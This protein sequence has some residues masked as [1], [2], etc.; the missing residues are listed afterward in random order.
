MGYLD[1]S[2]D[3]PHVMD[4][5]QTERSDSAT[6]TP[7]AQLWRYTLSFPDHLVRVFVIAQ[8]DE[9]REMLQFREHLSP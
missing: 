4:L 6:T 9:F 5:R 8:H 3:E 7:G 1:G 2:E